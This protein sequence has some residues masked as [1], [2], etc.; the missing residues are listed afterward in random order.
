MEMIS[1]LRDYRGSQ[2]GT[3]LLFKE[4]SQNSHKEGNLQRLGRGQGESEI[5]IRKAIREYLAVKR[6]LLSRQLTP[7][8]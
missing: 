7:T 2:D 5:N 3:R 6:S 8:L 4:V 1:G